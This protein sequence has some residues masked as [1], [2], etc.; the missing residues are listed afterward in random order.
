MKYIKYIILV[1][2]L[3]KQTLGC[4]I[5]DPTYDFSFKTLFGSDGQPLNGIKPK[6]RLSALLTSILQ[7]MFQIRVVNLTYEN[8]ESKSGDTKDLLFD[9]I[10][11]CKC[12]QAGKDLPYL[13]DLEIQRVKTSNFIARTIMYGNRLANQASRHATSYDEQPKNIVISIID[14]VLNDYPNDIVF[15]VG[16]CFKTVYSLDNGTPDGTL[17]YNSPLQVF[18]QLPL[19]CQAIKNKIS[20]EYT[21]NEWLKLLG[22]RRIYEGIDVKYT[23][24]GT[25]QLKE[26]D[27]NDTTVKN[28]VQVLQLLNDNIS[29]YNLNILS[30]NRKLDNEN[31]NKMQLEKKE[32]EIKE[33]KIKNEKLIMQN[34]LIRDIKKY[35]EYTKPEKHNDVNSYKFA[36]R[37]KGKDKKYLESLLSDRQ[38][39]SVSAQQYLESISKS[40]SI[41]DEQSMEEES[42]E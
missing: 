6:D 19:L 2:L 29:D 39:E 32:L 33:M 21:Q 25:Y 34:L 18:I 26:A 10:V 1:L 28:S 20:N 42:F 40:N 23:P 22:S 12:Q 30:Q 27:F 15:Y 24:N 14:D 38:K 11:S 16:P 31:A 3:I 8:S 37:L 41:F 17:T 9:I 35:K 4:T 5:V 7:P 36:K 13:I